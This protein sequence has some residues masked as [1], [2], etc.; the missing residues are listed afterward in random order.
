MK[1]TVVIPVYNERDT[2][3]QAIRAVQAT[4]LDHEVIVVDDGS[5]DGTSEVLQRLEGPGVRVIRQPRRMGKGM[6]I[7]TALPAATG[8]VVVIHDADLEYDP[9][10]FR[11]MLW[12][13]ASGRAEVV[14]GSRFRGHLEGMRLPN[15][16]IN[17]ILAWLANLL[18]RAGITDEATCYKMFRT[19]LLKRIPLQCRGFEFCP[20]VTAKVRRRG[21]RIVEVPITYRARPDQSSKKIRWTDGIKAITTLLHYRLWK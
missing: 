7:R 4:G 11:P 2:V 20:E 1:L 3:E 17:R 8:E 14:Y 13:I 15:R 10:D 9:R 12:T 18:Y 6:A 16:I 19:D 5:D 21:V